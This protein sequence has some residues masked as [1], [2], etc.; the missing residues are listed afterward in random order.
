[1][2][3]RIFDVIVVVVIAVFLLGLSYFDLLEEYAK[4]MFIP[5]FAFY[6]IGQYAERRFKD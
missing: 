6:L 4:F 3:K 2:N 1:M 5:I